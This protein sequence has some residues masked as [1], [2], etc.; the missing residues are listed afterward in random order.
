ME[1]NTVEIVRF[2]RQDDRAY[3]ILIRNGRYIAYR[4]LGRQG[5]GWI[6]AKVDRPASW[7]H[8]SGTVTPHPSHDKALA[9][10][11]AW[12]MLHGGAS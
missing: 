9:S 3:D 11:L 6:R 2:A 8:A 4:L 5:T 12:H 7:L 10:Y 1:A